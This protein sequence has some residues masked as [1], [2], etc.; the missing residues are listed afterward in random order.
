MKIKISTSKKI[1]PSPQTICMIK[2]IAYTYRLIKEKGKNESY[3][4]N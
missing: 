3:S 4:I 1:A 2:Q